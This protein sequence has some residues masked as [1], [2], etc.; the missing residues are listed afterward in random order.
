MITS[1]HTFIIKIER[2]AL[3]N[4]APVVQEHMTFMKTESYTVI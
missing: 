4:F 3:L 1:V 2:T